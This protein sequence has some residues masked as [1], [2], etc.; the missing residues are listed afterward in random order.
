MMFCNLLVR[1]PVMTYASGTMQ[2]NSVAGLQRCPISYAALMVVALAGLGLCQSAEP[3]HAHWLTKLIKEAGEAGGDAASVGGRAVRTGID[4]LDGAAAIVRR[5]PERPGRL[6][7]AAHATPEGHWKFVNRS[8]ETYTAGTPD[9]MARFA[10]S[11]SPDGDVSRKL[12]LYLSEETVFDQRALLKDLPRDAKLNIVS[13][14]QSF[15]LVGSA[16]G[17]KDDLRAVLRPNVRVVLNDHA[18]FKESV[19]QLARPLRKAD[20]RIVSLQPDGPKSLR[21][22]PKLDKATGGAMVDKI[23]PAQLP[24][25]LSSVRG[26]TVV[27]SGQVDGDFFFFQPASGARQ[28]LPLGTLRHAAEQADVNLV[29]LRS[30]AARQPG[31]RNWLWQRVQVDGLDDALK[32]ATLADFLNALGAGR[33]GFDVHARALGSG[34]VVIDGVRGVSEG[35]PLTDI[36]GEFMGDVVSELTGN[37]VTTAVSVNVRSRERQSELDSRI[38]PGLPS[39]YQWTYLASLIAGV[40][41]LGVARAWWVSLWP[42]ELR[43]EHTSLVGYQAARVVRWLAFLLVFLPVV[44]IPALVVSLALK[45]WAFVTWPFY[46]F[47]R[48]LGWIQPKPQ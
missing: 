32:R 12:D 43:S 34:R 28:S 27:L 6:A 31:G 46:F 16:A 29:M 14:K 17:A 19:W 2:S 48:L 47:G 35:V 33:G 36:V 21:A 26:Q 9:E 24:E 38:I 37:V 39:T 10:K 15:R 20:V 7:L 30:N 42:R 45:V 11:L 25:A 1:V 44:G 22:A 41:G 13:G 18:S 4:A 23:D 8:G 40:I 3:A 5:L